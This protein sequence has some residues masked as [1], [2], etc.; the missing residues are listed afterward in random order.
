MCVCL[1][2]W[3]DGDE[4]EIPGEMGFRQWCGVATAVAELRLALSGL[5]PKTPCRI[6][7]CGNLLAKLKLIFP[8]MC[9]GVCVGVHAQ[10]K[11]CAPS[12]VLKCVCLCGVHCTHHNVHNVHSIRENG[13]GRKRVFHTHSVHARSL[14]K[15]GRNSNTHSYTLE[16]EV[17]LRLWSVYLDLGAILYCPGTNVRGMVYIHACMI[18][19]I[20]HI[21]YN[22]N[23]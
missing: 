19:S 22:T 12:C 23:I 14:A 20:L 6:S 9:H 16:R 11:M 4:S 13:S 7:E 10:Q 21:L 8:C 3:R 2:R 17:L 5:C 1:S 18:G 15:L